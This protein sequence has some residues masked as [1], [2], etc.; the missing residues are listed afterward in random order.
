MIANSE[1]E[2]I[3]ANVLRERLGK[4]GFSRSDVVFDEDF[5]GEEII[6]VTA[7]VETP[8]ADVDELFDSV[9]AIRDQLLKAKDKRFV[10]LSQDYPGSREIENE[11]EGDSSRGTH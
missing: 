8:V 4:N 7:H 10:F 5:D 9:Y 11:D 3:I 2:K 1:V 6:R